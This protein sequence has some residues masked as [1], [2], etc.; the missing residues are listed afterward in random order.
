MQLIIL[1]L[2]PEYFTS[3][4]SVSILKRAVE[5]HKINV[6]IINIR[7]FAT[8]VHHVTDDRPFGGGPGMV[9]KIEP[10]DRALQYCREKLISPG[11]SPLVVLTSAKGSPFNQATA[12]S[13]SRQ[14]SIIIICGHYEGIDER[15]TQHLIDVET[16]IGDYVLTGG[17]PAAAVIAD[18]VCRLLPGVVGNEDSTKGESHGTEGELGFPQYTRPEVYQDWTVP[19]ELLTGNHAQIAAWREQ[20]RHREQTKD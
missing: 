9:M 20:N 14:E 13:W 8:D 11:V 5:G 17:E 10:I 4:F 19:S 12:V 7:D 15:V 16:R 6:E 1:T 3:V 18:A 2:F